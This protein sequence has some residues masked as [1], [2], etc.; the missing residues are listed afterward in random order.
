MNPWREVAD[1]IEDGT[2]DEL[3][4]FLHSLND[5]GRRAV[6]AHLPSYVAEVRREGMEGRWWLQDRA[7]QVARRRGRVPER[8][9][10]GRRL[11]RPSGPAPGARPAD[12]RRPHRVP[13][14]PRTDEWRADLAVRLVEG[15]R[16]V[17]RRGFDERVP[18]WELAAALVE[19]TGVEP[20]GND[21]F[22]EGWA[23]RL[24]MAVWM[25]QDVP[26]LLDVVAPRL[27]EAAGV[28]A[29]LNWSE[30]RN[31]GVS[32]AAR[33][34][35]MAAD[36]LVKRETMVD[37]CAS[38]FMAG[39][40]PEEVAPFVTLWSCLAVDVTE[41]PVLD[42]VRLLPSASPALAGLLAGELR[43]AD[44]AGLLDDELFGEAVRSLAFRPEKKN[45]AAALSWIADRTTP[46]RAPRRPARP[47]HRVLREVPPHSATVPPAS[48]PPSPTRPSP[49]PPRGPPPLLVG[50]PR[51]VARTHRPPSSRRNR[52]LSQTAK[53]SRGRWAPSRS[54]RGKRGPPRTS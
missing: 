4:T 10:A 36:G 49:P 27:F 35:G 42:F 37:G 38:R 47:R 1:R 19:A 30:A 15:L 8:G 2:L 50:R 22:A 13:A 44:A 17:R 11:A 12:R 31:H 5:L 54:F 18:N 29:A 14:L 3:V 53:T 23:W 46:S 34:A 20:P 33:L 21:A 52:R 6:A 9:G 41:I 25:T 43:R 48:P 51:K 7:P 32:A 24:A 28:A 45:V 40:A 16:P 39:G 26:P